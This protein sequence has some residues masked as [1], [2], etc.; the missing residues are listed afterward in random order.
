MAM[1]E[2]RVCGIPCLIQ[3]DSYHHQPPQGIHADS[4]MDCYG[5]TEIDFTVC[6]TKGKPAAWLER[7]MTDAD[8][9]A[10]ELLVMQARGDA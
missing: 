10:V 6:T 9:E 8:R 3:V 5:Y 2:A 1:I 4:D 7:K